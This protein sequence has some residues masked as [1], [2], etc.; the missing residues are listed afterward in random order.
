MV[1]GLKLEGSRVKASGTALYRIEGPCKSS[2][3]GSSR[4]L[5]RCSSQIHFDPKR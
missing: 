3:E 2:L 4:H 1:Q 5:Q